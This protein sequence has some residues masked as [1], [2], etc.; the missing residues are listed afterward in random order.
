MILALW[1]RGEMSQTE[2]ASELG[3]SGAYVN[4]VLHGRGPRW[5]KAIGPELV[6]QPITREQLVECYFAWPHLSTPAELAKA[7]KADPR[8]VARMCR[9][10]RLPFRGRLWPED[11][12][13]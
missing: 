7:Y 2:I 9:A 1:K 5:E 3:C 11:R 8:V 10:L 6:Y 4:K 13:S 12:V